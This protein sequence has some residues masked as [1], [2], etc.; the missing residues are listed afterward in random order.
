MIKIEHIAPNVLKVV[1]PARLGAD[2]FAALAPQV[3]TIIKKAGAV[4]LLIDAS[5]LEGWENLPALEHHAAFVKT[6]QQKVERIAIIAAHE[7]QHWLVGAVKV[8]LHPEVRVFDAS[9]AGEALHWIK[10]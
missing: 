4:R 2:D 10:G 3:E 8:F 5:N 1:A 9:E 7:W 6:H